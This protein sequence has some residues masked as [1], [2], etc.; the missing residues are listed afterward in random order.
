MSLISF[1]N[2]SLL[3]FALLAALPV[4]IH[5]LFRR[6]FKVVRWAAMEFLAASR[7]KT[8][9]LMRLKHLLLLILRCL[10]LVLIAVALSQP[11]IKT[12]GLSLF[13][14]RPSVYA[15]II[16]DTSYSMGY[17]TLNGTVFEDAKKKAL[18]A[19]GL[20][21]QGDSVSLI[22][23][24]W[25]AKAVINEPSYQIGT[26]KREIERL[27]VSASGNDLAGALQAAAGLLK[28][29]KENIKEVYIYTDCQSLVFK[30]KEA[31]IRR[32]LAGISALA[33]VYLVQAGSGPA[34]EN[35]AVE[36]LAFSREAVDTVLPVRIDCKLSNFG[37]ADATDLV[38]GL[39][40]DDKAKDSKRL[41]IRAKKSENVSFFFR[42]SDSG[43]HQGYVQISDDPL[44]IDNRRY[45]SVNVR[46][47]IRVLVIDGKPSEKPF[48]NAG[49]YLVSAFSPFGSADGPAKQAI[50]PDTENLYSFSA[51]GL[52]KYDVL[53][54]SNAASLNGK[55]LEQ[56]ENFVRKGKGLIVFAG[57][58][59]ESRFYNEKLFKEKSGLLPAQLNRIETV[60]SAGDRF[61]LEGISKDHPVLAGFNEAQIKELKKINFTSHWGLTADAADPSV[62][63]LAY[64]N[65][66][67]PAIAGKRYGRGEVLL[68]PCG[69]DR[70]WSDLPVRNM[71]LPLLYEC[72][73]YLCE[74]SETKRNLKV[75]DSLSRLLSFSEFSE[76]PRIVA[77]D[78]KIM[79]PRTGVIPEGKELSFDNTGLPGI[80]ELVFGGSETVSD[81]FAVNP[82]TVESNTEKA[83]K[84]YLAG[85][86][87]GER[88]TIVEE[89]SDIRQI[90]AKFRKGI[91]IWR[92]VLIL[93]LCLMAAE[94]ILALFYGKRET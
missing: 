3:Y 72:V 82:E 94:S 37:N 84:D 24:G 4:I 9:K 86:A 26:A 23:A 89:G 32:N 28:N 57:D 5:L 10:I 93:L 19:L 11:L 36:S 22:T 20:L 68:F 27:A 41:S 63:V 71:F 55:S 87:P 47:N 66:G 7:E 15:V 60:K 70:L 46:D 91:G 21:G 40:I 88:L 14:G 42:F 33:R 54:L 48:E 18:E 83:G 50:I 45:F 56:V 29:S 17:K 38:A 13:K 49:D 64:F 67:K 65:D 53:I 92:D 35:I 90:V 6:R 76:S 75:G 58:L 44:A 62:S 81:F 1:S 12:P 39:Y 34:T 69:A 25:K 61:F 8:R 52:G 79:A 77:P 78:K 43:P 31:E 2:P 59:A 16:M 74:G 30:E 85:L 51:Q 80:Y 73:Y